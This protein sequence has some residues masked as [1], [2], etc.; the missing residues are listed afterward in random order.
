M[1]VLITGAAKGIGAQTAKLFADSGWRVTAGYRTGEAQAT[2]LAAQTDGISA[3]YADIT[4]PEDVRR[5]VGQ[6]TAKN[7]PVDVLVNNAGIS[8]VKLFSDLTI[9][10]WHTMI[11]TNLTGAFLCCKAVLPDMLSRKSGKIINISSV[12][13]ISGASCEVHYSASKAGLI[14]FTK[15]LAK[16]L[17]P[18]NIQVNC[19][20]PGVIDTEMNAHLNENDFALL[21]GQTP[22]QRIG[23]ALEVAQ[24]IYY[25]GSSGGFIT[26]QTLTV[27]GG[28]CL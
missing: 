21:C 25:L 26:G 28:F 15:A 3:I 23:T 24:A 4:K 1:H 5:L 18:S 27:D 16:E 12:W 19:I 10:D 9:E 11:D 13:G 6:A 20:A 2:A 8:Q 7:G 22:M 14:G 17:G